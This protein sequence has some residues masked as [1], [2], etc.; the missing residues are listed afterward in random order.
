MLHM[1]VNT[2]NAESCAFRGADEGRIL[3][4]AFD[5]LAA[6]AGE[7][8]VSVEGSWINRA[9]HEAFILVNA[10]NAN[11][12]EEALLDAGLVGRTHSRVLSVIP[13]DDVVVDTD[14]RVAELAR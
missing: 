4:E 2:H 9:A 1:I 12:I 13:T 5:R 11:A 7:Q 10:P 6:G 3:T 14:A 8:G